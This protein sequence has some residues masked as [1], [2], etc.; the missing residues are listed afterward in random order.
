MK[1]GRVVNIREAVIGPA[2][3]SADHQSIIQKA[4]DAVALLEGQLVHARLVVKSSVQ[5]A[6][7]DQGINA[8]V[9]DINNLHQL[10]DGRFA[11]PVIEQSKT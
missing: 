6:A 3:V 11:F 8:K 10:E 9:H 5:A 1:K 7:L 2:R 4:L